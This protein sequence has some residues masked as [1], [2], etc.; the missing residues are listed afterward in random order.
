[1][2]ISSIAGEAAFSAG[3]IAVAAAA[4]YS[5]YKKALEKAVNPR[6]AGVFGATREYHKGLYFGRSEIPAPG[7][8][9]IATD[10]PA[11]SR[12]GP[13]TATASLIS[14]AQALEGAAQKAQPAEEKVRA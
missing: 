13:E 9:P 3:W 2:S 7:S 8:E 4:A 1:M 11:P 5:R 6:G 12:I 14:L 10:L